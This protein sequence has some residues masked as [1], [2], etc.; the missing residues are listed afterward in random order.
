MA[1]IKTGG[2]D[3]DTTLLECLSICIW[4]WSFR[5]ENFQVASTFC[6]HSTQK[7]STQRLP[8]KIRRKL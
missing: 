8:S 3:D 6:V 2:H 5:V 4:K 7:T 1:T